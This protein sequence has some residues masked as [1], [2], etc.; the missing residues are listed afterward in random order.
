M[1]NKTGFMPMRIEIGGK[2]GMKKKRV[3]QVIADSLSTGTGA[4]TVVL[5]KNTSGLC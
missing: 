3:I 5:R 4:L 1:A 2:A